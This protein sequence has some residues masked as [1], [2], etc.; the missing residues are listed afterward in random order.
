MSTKVK[1]GWVPD[2]N[3]QRRTWHSPNV[4]RK[5]PCFQ[6]VGMFI[7]LSVK[8][9]GIPAYN[10]DNLWLGRW[11]NKGGFWSMVQRNGDPKYWEDIVVQMFK[12]KDFLNNYKNNI[13]EILKYAECH[14]PS[15]FNCVSL[16]QFS[17]VQIIGETYCRCL[18][19]YG[20]PN[21]DLDGWF[22]DSGLPKKNVLD[23]FK[24]RDDF[25]FRMKLERVMGP[26]PW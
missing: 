19:H 9:K 17:S 21:P 3:K 7:S 2:K 16:D 8:C 6:A 18:P 4:I 13:Q 12:D 1:G 14:P 11:G 26:M 5:Q 24:L 15:E 23:K 20:D 10:F 22:E 25:R